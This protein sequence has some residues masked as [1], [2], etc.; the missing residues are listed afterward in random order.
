MATNDTKPAKKKAGQTL[1]QKV[2]A[3]ER[4][5]RRLGRSDDK[6]FVDEAWRKGSGDTEG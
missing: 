6:A 5:G 2:K 1:A 4:G 3:L